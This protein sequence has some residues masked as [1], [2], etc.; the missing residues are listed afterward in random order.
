MAAPPSEAESKVAELTKTRKDLV[1]GGFKDKHFNWGSLLLG[2]GVAIAI[3]GA[4]ACKSAHDCSSE[5][6][7]PLRGVYAYKAYVV[8]ASGLYSLITVTSG[9]CIVTHWICPSSTHRPG[10]HL[11][12]HREALSGAA[13]LRWGCDRRSLG[14]CHLHKCCTVTSPVSLL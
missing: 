12:S 4:R 7:S 13:P 5:V 3:E 6:D 9:R 11:H 10:E 2:L 8:D 14:A 1:A